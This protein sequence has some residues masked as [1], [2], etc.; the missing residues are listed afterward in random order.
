[1]TPFEPTPDPAPRRRKQRRTGTRGAL[2]PWLA[3][4]ILERLGDLALEPGAHITEQ[5]LADHFRVSRTPV[6]QALALLAETSAVER[7]PNRGYFV[8]QPPQ[9]VSRSEVAPPDD[10]RLYHR[11]AE[12]RLNGRL[13]QRF[14]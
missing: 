10:D 11:I 1:M 3:A 5:G 6:R 13:P 14:T 12:D 7:R 2:I 9:A 8:A 4:R